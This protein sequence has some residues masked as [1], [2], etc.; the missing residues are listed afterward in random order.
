M[1]MGE[2]GLIRK[3]REEVNLTVM[4]VPLKM[5]STISGL[6]GR[7]QTW[8]KVRVLS[9]PEILR[10]RARNALESHWNCPGTELPDLLTHF[11]EEF[12]LGI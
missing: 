11:I 3:G 6:K 7:A 8:S 10:S 5:F 4:S 12:C 1:Q 9:L 2:T